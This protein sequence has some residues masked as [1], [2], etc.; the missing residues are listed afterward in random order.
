MRASKIP[1]HASTLIL[2]DAHVHLYDCFDL[3]QVLYAAWQN[4]QG[5]ACQFNHHNDYIGILFLTETHSDDYF[6][7]LYKHANS[8]FVALNSKQPNCSENHQHWTFFRTQESYSLIAQSGDSK[9]LI[10]IAGRQIIT[11]EKLEILALV[12][13]HTFADEMPLE[14]AIATI[15]AA[16]GIPVLPWGVGKWMGKRGDRLQSLLKQ[17]SLPSLF[18]GDNS[19]RPMFWVRSPFFRQ[20]ETQ[21]LRILPGTDPLPLASEYQRPG[22]FGFQSHGALSWQQPGQDIKQLLLNPST[23]MSPYGSLENPFRFIRNQLQLCF[24]KNTFQKPA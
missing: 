23:V 14:E 15:L 19:G 21:G 11:A 13:D 5:A 8:Q 7:Q 17:Q 12:T 3:D 1:Q 9:Q 2:A 4:F 16:G 20:A 6:H 24:Q 22:S 10:L 18:L